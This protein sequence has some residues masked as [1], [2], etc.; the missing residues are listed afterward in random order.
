M[1]Y[2]TPARLQNLKSEAQELSYIVDYVN[3]MAL[4][5]PQLA[6]K[7]YNNEKLLVQTYG[8]N[9]LLEVIASI[10]GMDIAKNMVKID[11]NDGYYH[12]YGYTSNIVTTRSSRN[13]IT[14]IVNGRVVRNNNIINAVVAGYHNLLMTGR[15]PLSVINIKVDTSLVDVNVHPA[16]L[17]VRFSN[18]EGL[19]NLIKEAIKTALV[20]VDLTVSLDKSENE[21]PYH[22]DIFVREEVKPYPFTAKTPDLEDLEEDQKK[23]I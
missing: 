11:R 22:N 14:I 23:R 8:S 6:F 5:N 7:L 12:I 19:I 3:K 4:A 16:K 20:E 17:E 9:D 21:S 2:N 1:F 10:Y 13:S 15:Y 18:E